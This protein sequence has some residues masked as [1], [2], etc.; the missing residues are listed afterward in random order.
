MNPTRALLLGLVTAAAACSSVRY[1]S[2]YD[3]EATFAQ[4]KSY[5]WVLPTEDEQ[6]ALERVNPFLER[7]LQR[8]IE[9][10]LADRGFTKV[11]GGGPDFLVSV[12]PLLP[13]RSAEAGGSARDGRGGAYSSSRV[14]M[15]VGFGIGFGYPY[16]FGFGYPYWYG[17][18]YPSWYSLG[19]PYGFGY[20]WI[21]FG[22][23]YGFRYGYP[24]SFGYPYRYRGYRYPYFGYSRYAWPSFAVGYSVGGYGYPRVITTDRLGPGTIVV[25]VTDARTDELVWRGWAEGALY[26]LPQGEQITKYIDELVARIMKEFPPPTP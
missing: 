4:F 5:A 20:P 8:A 6:A 23:P 22:Y 11:D 7:R 17:F 26:E 2:D 3:P 24:Y 18:G 25:D 15:S 19:Y 13:A 1:S 12:Y 9:L 10:Q 16:A 14:H 21:G